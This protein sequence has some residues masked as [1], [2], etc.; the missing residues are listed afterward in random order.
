MSRM[1]QEEEIIK[2]STKLGVK[3]PPVDGILKYC[4]R[5][6][7]A[8][9]ADDSG[10]TNINELE[11]LV[12]KNLNLTFEEFSSDEEFNEVCDRYIAG[13]DFV[14]A[15]M[16][17]EMTPDTF[18]ATIRLEDHSYVALIDARDDKAI[19]IGEREASQAIEDSEFDNKVFQ[20]NAARLEQRLSS[21]GMLRRLSDA[22]GYVLN[23][24][25]E[26]TR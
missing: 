1:D 18:G 3:G 7:D 15:S 23:P 14:F 10:V 19:V 20:S 22:C 6:V 13:G 2:L 17:D 21:L 9:V 25:A 4:Q 24:Y 8:W 16:D 26:G 12:A 5:R 11:S